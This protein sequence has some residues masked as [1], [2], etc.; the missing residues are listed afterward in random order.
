[1]PILILIFQPLFNSQLLP[2]QPAGCVTGTPLL[3]L[4]SKNMLPH[5]LNSDF[6]GTKPKEAANP[7]TGVTS[8]NN[9]L[10][11]ILFFALLIGVNFLNIL[12]DF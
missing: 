1:M 11:Q 9:S 5:F 6:V 10:T 12:L 7:F 3:S 4:F 2:P 8:S